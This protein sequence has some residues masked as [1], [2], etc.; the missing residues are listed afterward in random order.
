M[1]LEPLKVPEVK[2]CSEKDVGM[3]H[4]HRHNWK[5]HP[6]A[7]LGQSVQLNK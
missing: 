7:K 4:R 5:R 2:R 6:T 1:N 3:S